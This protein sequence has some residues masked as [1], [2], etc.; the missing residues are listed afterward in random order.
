MPGVSGVGLSLG[1]H[2]SPN[3]VTNNGL[4]TEERL[5]REQQQQIKDTSNR[6]KDL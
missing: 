3:S 5:Q 1:A 6:N 4:D 2:Q